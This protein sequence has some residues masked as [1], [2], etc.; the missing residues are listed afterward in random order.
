MEFYEVLSERYD[1]LFPLESEILAFLR[2]SFRGARSV[3]DAACGT[4]TYAEELVEDGRRVVGIDLDERMIAKAVAKSAGKESA[5]SP[6]YRVG[7]MLKLKDRF[8]PEFDGLACIGNS[9]VHL[10]S[11]ASVREALEGFHAV[12]APKGRL[13]VQIVNFDRVAARGIRELPTLRG[14]GAEL[15]RRYL[16]SGDAGSLV[17]ETE[18]V[19]SRPDGEAFRSTQGIPLLSLS[20]GELVG[21]AES[22]GFRGIELFG[23]YGRARY[24]AEESFLTI[25]SALKP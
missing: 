4:G 1:D 20:S 25:L 15:V 22:S 23:S 13:V 8:G 10:G 14:G 19:V 16:P 17:F 12:L 18:L 2:E 21:F 7:D 24:I 9:L 11:R 6:E 3:L 5:G